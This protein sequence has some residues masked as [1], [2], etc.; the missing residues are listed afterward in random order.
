MSSKS[1]TW[2]LNDSWGVSVDSFNWVLMKRAAKGKRSWREA[3][4]YPSAQQ[5]LESLHR[6]LTRTESPDPDLI[7]H[8]KHCSEAA[9]GFTDALNQQL[10]SFIWRDLRRPT[11][12]PK[13]KVPDK[14]KGARDE[15]YR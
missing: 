12:P 14:K 13:K 9:Q 8:L 15:D 2:I 3:G 4:Y 1:P 6:K 10:E 11:A 7:K 5:L